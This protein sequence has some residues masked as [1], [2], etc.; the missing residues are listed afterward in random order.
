MTIPAG[1]GLEP[2]TE[3][4]ADRMVAAIEAGDFE[5]MEDC[6]APGAVIWHCDDNEEVGIDR[7]VRTL[8][9][10]HRHVDNLRYTEIRR[11][12]LPGAGYVQQHVLRATTHDGQDLCVPACLVV[13]VDRARITR[14]DEYLD[15]GRVAVLTRPRQ[16]ASG[17]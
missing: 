9:W 10:L 8:R 17:S 11:A 7:V 4:L 3:D 2:T 12:P 13:E 15:S 14:L 16:T 5:A 6:F 1:T